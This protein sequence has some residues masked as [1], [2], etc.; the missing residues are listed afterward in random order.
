M[1]TF[2]VPIDSEVFYRAQNQI[3]KFRYVYVGEGYDHNDR[4]IFYAVEGGHRMGLPQL[5]FKVVMKD[6]FHED[7][8]FGEFVEEIPV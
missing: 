8:C 2:R 5:K 1:T 3:K 6:I 7:W 4:I